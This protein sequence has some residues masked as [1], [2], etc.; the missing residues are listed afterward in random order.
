MTTS[1]KELT[2][3]ELA[4]MYCERQVQTPEGLREVLVKQAERFKPIGWMLLEAQDMSSSWMGQL[5][6]MPYGPNNTWKEIVDRPISPRG[7]A[8]DMSVVVGVLPVS[9]IDD[10]PAG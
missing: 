2:F 3:D 1:V 8:S 7:L 9:E 5:V 4:S 6:L 10:S